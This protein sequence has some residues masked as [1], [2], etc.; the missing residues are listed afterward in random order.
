M[1]EGEK[2][3]NKHTGLIW[4]CYSIITSTFGKVEYFFHNG[5]KTKRIDKSDF[6]KYVIVE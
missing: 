6:R 3:K 2:L 5:G 1:K 4:E